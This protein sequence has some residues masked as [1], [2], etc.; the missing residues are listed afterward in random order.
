LHEQPE[1]LEQRQAWL[2]DHW[3]LL[4]ASRMERF[5]YA[6]AIAKERDILCQKLLVWMSFW[7]DVLLRSAGASSLLT[8][9]DREAEISNLAS[10]FEMA[11]A[12]RMVSTIQNTL[13]L[14]DRNVNTRL[15]TEVLLLKLPYI[16]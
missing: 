7:R 5:A 12:H 15:A 8:N 6:D 4:S 13:N 3:R 16:K 1:Q 2:D 11:I 9:P 10:Q 14:L